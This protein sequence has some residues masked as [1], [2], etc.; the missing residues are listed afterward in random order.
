MHDEF[1]YIYG[2]LDINRDTSPHWDYPSDEPMYSKH[3]KLLER[4]VG[5]ICNFVFKRTADIGAINANMTTEV[6]GISQENILNEQ[7]KKKLEK[8]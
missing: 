4:F 3:A 7:I 8:L 6:L 5:I 2:Y 1:K